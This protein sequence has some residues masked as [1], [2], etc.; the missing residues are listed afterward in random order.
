MKCKTKSQATWVKKQLRPDID[1]YVSRDEIRFA[2]LQEGEDYF[3]HEK[4]VF[5][6]FVE[7]IATYLKDENDLYRVFADASHLNYGS[8]MKL[9]NALKEQG[10]NFSTI[11][12]NYIF[13]FTSL[14]TCLMRNSQRE[15]RARVPDRTIEEMH[16]S[17]SEPEHEEPVK[18]VYII[19]EHRKC[20]DIKFM[21]AKDT[22]NFE[23]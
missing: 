1:A 22:N 2:L 18:R 10:V 13:M 15:G 16:R 5:N 12:V 23:F 7:K 11:D 21:D 19:N 9:L 17:L 8:R 4:E 14:E 3:A 20:I 6:T